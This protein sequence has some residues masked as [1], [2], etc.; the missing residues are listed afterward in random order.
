M[1]GPNIH[2]VNPGEREAA[3]RPA[4]IAEVLSIRIRAVQLLNH[5]ANVRRVTRWFVRKGSRQPGLHLAPAAGVADRVVAT[6]TS[7]LRGCE[8]ED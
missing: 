6:V 3:V 8:A 7:C 5:A 4:V 2:P 1:P